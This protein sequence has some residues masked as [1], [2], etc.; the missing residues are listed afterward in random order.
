VLD[1]E[2]DRAIRTEV[3]GDLAGPASVELA[4]H[5]D[6]TAVRLSWEL[7]VARR[8]LRTAAALA[9]PVLEW[10][11]D[12]V[13]ADGIAQFSRATDITAHLSGARPQPLERTSRHGSSP[14][15]PIHDG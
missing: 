12:R 13:V 14:P 2:P 4:E 8:G 11:H 9:R 1:L 15:G 7:E 6:G 10:G 3:A 5:P